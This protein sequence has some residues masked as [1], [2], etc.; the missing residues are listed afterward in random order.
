MQWKSFHHPDIS[1]PVIRR[2]VSDELITLLAGTSE[3]LLSRGLSTIYGNC[4]P[5]RHAYHAS[6]S[7]LR[8]RGLVATEKS[9]GSLPSLKLTPE[10]KAQLPSYYAP[11][12]FWNKKWSSRWYILMFDVPEKDRSYR[13]NLRAFLKLRHFGCLQKSVW[14][15]PR[16][17]RADYDDLNKAA[18]VDSVAFLF[19]AQTVLGFGHQS[20][21][22]EAWDFYRINQLQQF[23]IQAAEENINRLDEVSDPEPEILQLLRMDNEAYAQVMS[24]DPLLPKELHPAEYEGM[25]VADLHRELCRRAIEKL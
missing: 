12:K 1:L 23:Y 7:R 20:V 13:D 3:L 10:A 21:V 16:D 22:R 11:Q 18:S 9:D 15:T 25:R 8:N 14:V 5:N 24:I 17:V 6:V 4:Y 19:E 2:R